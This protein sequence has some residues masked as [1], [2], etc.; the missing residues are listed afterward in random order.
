MEITT[1][2]LD[3]AKNVFQVHGVDAADTVVVRK[4]LRRAQ[5][6]PF[7]AKLS[8]CLVGI[9]ACG[10]S[11]HW[12]RELTVLGHEVRLMPPVY[13]KPYVKRGKNDAADAEAICEAVTRPTMRFV[14]IKSREQQGALSLHRVCKWLVGQRTQLVNLMR[15]QLGEF[16]IAIPA[17]LGHALTKARQFV[18]GEVAFDLPACA[19]KV[20]ELLAQ[21]ALDLH[22]RLREI[23]Q[24]IEAM[25]RSDELARR[26]AT[27]PGIGPIGATA[28]V[29]AVADPHQFRSG[30][31]FAAW[32]GLTPRQ[33]SS[34]GKERLGRITKMGDK[35]LRQ[36]LV[37]G[38]TSMIRRA[39]DRPDAVDPRLIALLARKPA[40]LVS[41]AMA[42]K[43]ARI[44]WAVMTRGQV[45]QARHEPVLVA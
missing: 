17:G 15:S 11:H 12:A 34:G 45:Y 27:I 28:L 4:A 26:L 19:A 9:E 6:L 43:M 30:R 10:T 29:A 40:K 31:Q 5:V 36:L 13:V 23:D 35:Y 38:A 24:R 3:L 41:V 18:D 22:T 20:I 2:G 25:L 1:I 42:N 16:G 37:I 14:P 21:Q 39:K 44:A 32:L 8:P 7:F 33:K